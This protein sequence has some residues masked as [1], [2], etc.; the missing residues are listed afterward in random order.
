MRNSNT[1]LSVFL[2]AATVAG[3]S[4]A[5]AAPVLVSLEDSKQGGLGPLSFAFDSQ[6]QAH[7]PYDFDDLKHHAWD[8]APMARD[9]RIRVEDYFRVEMDGWTGYGFNWLLQRP[10]GDAGAY[11]EYCEVRFFKSPEQ[12]YILKGAWTSSWSVD[13]PVSVMHKDGIHLH[14]GEMHVAGIGD[15]P[16]TPQ[17]VPEPGVLALFAGGLLAMAGAGSCRL[18][19]PTR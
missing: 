2:L 11:E 3:L 19:R 14:Y 15:P 9:L 7:P 5:A 4:A 10:P 17:A 6:R 8:L 1:S 16:G 13:A 18:R 12:A